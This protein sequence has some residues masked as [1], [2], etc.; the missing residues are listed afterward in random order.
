MRSLVLGLLKA[1]PEVIKAGGFWSP[2]FLFVLAVFAQP[3]T[4]TV[5]QS[6]SFLAL[7]AVTGSRLRWD[8]FTTK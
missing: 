3:L 8:L 2:H 7:G 1:A 4:E 5:S 6:V